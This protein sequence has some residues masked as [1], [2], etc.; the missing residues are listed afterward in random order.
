MRCLIKRLPKMAIVIRMQFQYSTL[1]LNETLIL[2]ITK[3]KTSS[4]SLPGGFMIIYAKH[5]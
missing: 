3:A 1:C 2:N 4:L 5:I